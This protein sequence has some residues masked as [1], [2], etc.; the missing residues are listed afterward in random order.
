MFEAECPSCKATYQVDERRVPSTGLKMRCPKCG[1]SFQ[2]VAPGQSIP[3]ILGA[4]LGLGASPKAEGPPRH[5]A[6][7]LGVPEQSGN[8]R[9]APPRPGFGAPA[10]AAPPRPISPPRATKQTM[11][12]V[13]PAGGGFELASLDDDKLDETD[14]DELDLTSDPGGGRNLP[15]PSSRGGRSAAIDLPS[16]AGTDEA[17]DLE[18]LDLDADTELPE[19]PDD[20]FDLP[21]RVDIAGLP[22]RASAGLPARVEAGLPDLGSDEFY[23]DFPDLEAELPDLEAGLPIVGGLLPNRATGLPSISAPLPQNASALPQNASAL[24]QNAALPPSMVD[25]YSEIDPFE[26]SGSGRA[27]DELDFEAETSGR[28]SFGGLHLT[29]PAP[30]PSHDPADGSADDIF[31]HGPATTPESMP[32]PAGAGGASAFGDV[33]FGAEGTSDDD[34]FD[35]FPTDEGG[36]AHQAAGY[37]N[38]QLDGGSGDFDL[39]ED[40]DR[41][42]APGGLMPGPAAAASAAVTRPT[43][44]SKKSDK[45]KERKARVK[46]SGLSRGSR[47]MLGALLLAA[48]AGGALVMLPEV[49]PYGA[50]LVIDALKGDEYKSHLESD[51][52]ATQKRL[53]LDT[54]DELALA[55]REIERGR[56][57]APRYKPRAAY[58]AYLGYLHQLRF[59]ASSQVS[60]Q[61][62]VLM[63]GLKDLPAA[64]VEYLDLA[65]ITQA[66]AGGKPAEA[67]NQAP[68]LIKLGTESAVVVGES[69]L[70]AGNGEIALTAWKAVLSS[71]ATPR[72]HFGMARALQQAKKFDEVN[73]HIE[74]A[75]SGNPQHAG[76]RLLLAEIQLQRR[77]HDEEI[78]KSLT[79]LS[80]GK[81]VSQGEQVQALIL[82]GRLHLARARITKAEDSF[83]AALKLNAGSPQAQMG[84]AQVLFES[85]RYSE[86]LARFEAAVQAAP[87]NLQANLGL[88]QS[89]LR[90]E[91][92]EDAV[93]VLDVLVKKHPESSAVYFWV[94]RGKEEIGEKA[95]AEKAFEKAIKLGED[96]P[97]LVLSYIALTRLLSQKGNLEEANGVI[98]Q[99]EKRFP[100]DPT[101]YEALGELASS[102]G[103][104]DDAVADFD[105]ALRLDPNNIG[106]RFS[107]GVA[108]RQA[109]RFEE[110]TREFD[111]VQKESPTYP[112]LALERGNLY[113]SSGRTEEALK[114]YEE[115]LA[116]APEDKDLMLRVACGKASAG[117]YEPVL[118]LIAPLLEERANSAEVNFCQG[119]AM[120]NGGED[121]PSAQRYLQRAVM[122]DPT[123]AKHHLYV[124]WI[125]LQMG[126]LSQASGALDK[127]IELD[128]TLA[129]AYWK[130]GELRVRQRAVVDALRDLDRA[131]EL[132]P[133]RTEAYAQKAMAYLEL[134]KEQDAIL[135]YEKAVQTPAVDPSWNY[136]YGDLLLANQRPAEARAQLELAVE[137]GGKRNPPPTWLPNAHRLLAAAIGRHAD[138]IEHLKAYMDAK[139]GTN[140]PYLAEVLREL[141]A[142]LAMTGH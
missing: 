37:G 69:A 66:A 138:A 67:V 126:D 121:L 83:I 13:A 125:A 140:D 25:D 5:K 16:V 57:R 48:V 22:A 109:R 94:G 102:R 63:N 92:L 11:I 32:P 95:E 130:R 56:Q 111:L 33:K 1:E 64:E 91:Q 116:A 35:A 72:A 27:M 29:D 2:V 104:F 114:A 73:A 74:A 119:L 122:R 103:S 4:A 80:E 108:L 3:P 18:E 115:A 47:V 51:I 62:Q 20:E 81:G 30:P 68:R 60:A 82:L 129:D 127:A 45:K 15:V 137:A 38:V 17:D 28:A 84:L 9:Q 14:I 40:V 128:R 89:K 87:N 86:A 100:D 123:R 44:A 21:A 59:G 41:P 78:V 113:E 50:Y 120:L 98:V 134:G 52:K 61:A 71:G 93:K 110:A 23:S 99:A 132:A 118:K 105:K 36:G 12:G 42:P 141:S 34:E 97:E 133:S 112:G 54:A 79:P 24:P 101:V 107:R 106:L 31:G 65:R 88:V 7:M 96:T 46:T 117:Q 76:A 58:A 70:H 19:L 10:A 135:A 139:Q 49:G 90:L 55:F 131:L 77:D 26:S 124:G 43:A 53:A 39:S 75:L 136:K 8:A 6:T 142:I 85:G